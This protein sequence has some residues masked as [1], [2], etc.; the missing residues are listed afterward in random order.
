MTHELALIGYSRNCHRRYGLLATYQNADYK[1]NNRT[2][3]L[4]FSYMLEWQ[5]LDKCEDETRVLHWLP[6]L[7]PET[8]VSIILHI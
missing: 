8:H 5:S 3:S 6:G 4:L 1:G 7:L 2:Y